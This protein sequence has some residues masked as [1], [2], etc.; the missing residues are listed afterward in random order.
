MVDA[1]FK[2]FDRNHDGFINKE[3][4]QAICTN[5]P[6]IDAFFVLDENRQ[7]KNILIF[8][9]FTA[10]KIEKR[11]CQTSVGQQLHNLYQ[12]CHLLFIM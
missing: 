2:N 6:A 3:E 5:F 8:K 11:S 10:L 1:V 12:C 4:F 7:I 9:L